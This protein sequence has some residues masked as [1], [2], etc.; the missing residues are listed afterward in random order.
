MATGYDGIPVYDGPVTMGLRGNVGGENATWGVVNGKEVPIFRGPNENEGQDARYYTGQDLVKKYGS[1]EAAA[2]QMAPG[3][4][5]GY[6]ETA[7]GEGAPIFNIGIWGSRPS[8]DTFSG[9]DGL[10]DVAT[11]IAMAMPVLAPAALGVAA[12]TEGGAIAGTAAFEGASFGEMLNGSLQTVFADSFTMPSTFENLVGSGDALAGADTVTATPGATGAAD[13]GS[14]AARMGINTNAQ[15]FLVADSGTTMTD[16]SGGMVNATPASGPFPME[17]P[18]AFDQFGS[19]AMPGA[20]G[21]TVFDGAQGPGIIDSVLRF[22]KENPLVTAAGLQLGGGIIKGIG[23]NVT[24]NELMDRRVGADAALLDDRARKEQ[25]LEEWKRKFKQEGSYF[26]SKI[27]VKTGSTVLR[28]P[29]GSPVYGPNG[30][31][32]Q[33]MH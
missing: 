12:A 8:N 32:N 20:A 4:P 5:Q 2:K 18:G 10:R 29:D 23:D 19:Q 31:I 28:R 3:D 16:V 26:D 33:T 14:S 24:A 22:G 30:I 7:P 9:K 6:W 17:G 27:P 11:I 15:Q 25:E 13:A 1:I 21:G